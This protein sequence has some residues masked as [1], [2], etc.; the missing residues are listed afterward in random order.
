MS[1]PD[2]TRE[3]RTAT[4]RRAPKYGVFIGVGVVLGLVVAVVLTLAFPA[5]P[6][7]GMVPTVAYVSLY[8][9][10]AGGVLGAVVAIIADRTSRRHLRIVEVERGAIERGESVVLLADET[11]RPL[12][13]PARADGA[14]RDVDGRA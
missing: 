4:L 11:G 1:E 9:I 3:T 14:H 7:V 8:G 2:E 5:D 12:P 13:D 6:N 10:A